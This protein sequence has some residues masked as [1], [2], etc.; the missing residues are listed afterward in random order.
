MFNLPQKKTLWGLDNSHVTSF[1]WTTTYSTYNR[2]W[3]RTCFR[4][5]NAESSIFD[6]HIKRF[7]Q[8]R[9]ENMQQIWKLIGHKPIELQK[10][11][12]C[13][14]ALRRSL[15]FLKPR[16]LLNMNYMFY[17]HGSFWKLN[18]NILFSLFLLGICLL[19]IRRLHQ[20]SYAKHPTQR[21]G[22]KNHNSWRHDPNIFAVITS[23]CILDIPYIPWK[24]PNHPMITPR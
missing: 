1:S 17:L 24:H 4:H 16:K 3:D 5:P 13:R 8:N 2:H 23:D 18:Q 19:Q 14:L 12:C 21:K 20:K 10:I 9:S 11:R 22:N 6:L 7:S 15:E